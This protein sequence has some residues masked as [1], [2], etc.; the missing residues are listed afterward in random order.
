MISF[1]FC[2]F[3]HRAV[4]GHSQVL[5]NLRGT[6]VNTPVKGRLCAIMKAAVNRSPDQVI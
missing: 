2:P 4:V 1:M 5:T 3:Y 6:C